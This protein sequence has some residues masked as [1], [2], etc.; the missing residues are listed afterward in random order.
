M[1]PFYG[2]FDHFK[3]AVQSVLAQSDPDWRLVI[4]DDVYPDLAPGEWAQGLN[5]ERISY[6]RNDTNLRPSRN[7][8]KCV[9]LM[10]SEF[11]VILGCDDALLPHYVSRAKQLVVE[12]PSA[13]VIQPGVS[14]MDGDGQAAMPLV[15]RVKS[16]YRFRGTGARAFSGERLAKS[17]MRGNWTYFPSLVWRVSELKK[18]GFRVDLDVVQDLAML[19]EITKDG[20]TLVLDDDV[21][22]IYRRHGASVSAVTGPD[23][24]KFAQERILFEEASRDLTALGWQHAAI[25]A[26]LHLTSRLNALTDMPAAIRRGNARGRSALLRHVFGR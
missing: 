15:D 20:G 24:S 3:Q 19:L 9:T 22:F 13:A 8:I 18:H 7:Y 16:W 25:A 17:L 1:M 10:Q 26:R 14:I 6:I 21:S 23:G 12:F 4:V 11:A 2:R 5:D